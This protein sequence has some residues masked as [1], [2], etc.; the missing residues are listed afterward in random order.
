MA[1]EI[2]QARKEIHA[3]VDIGRDVFFRIAADAVAAVDDGGR[4]AAHG[5]E[6][7]RGYAYFQAAALQGLR[8]KAEEDTVNVFGRFGI[9]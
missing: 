3:F 5:A 1:V 8:L 6:N 9:P 4:F 2:G 7:R